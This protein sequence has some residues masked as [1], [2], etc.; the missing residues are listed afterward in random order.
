MC[1]QVNLAPL[2][3][4]YRNHVP[5]VVCLVS[6]LPHR[7]SGVPVLLLPRE[8]ELSVHQLL[9]HPSLQRAEAQETEQF[10]L[11]SLARAPQ[12]H[13]AP[14][15]SSFFG[16]LLK[17]KEMPDPPALF[18]WPALPLLPE[19]LLGVLLFWVGRR[20]CVLLVPWQ[21]TK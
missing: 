3:L 10:C 13:P 15:I 5:Q 16:T 9:Q 11:S 19:I 12:H 7:L 4:C 1:R 14:Q 8:T 18:F 17:L 2:D 20:L 21:I 6:G